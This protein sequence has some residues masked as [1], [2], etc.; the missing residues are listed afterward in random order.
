MQQ[1][2]QLFGHGTW[3]KREETAVPYVLGEPNTEAAFV[4]NYW[5]FD[6]TRNSQ[7]Y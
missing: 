4:V 3:S 7:G 5:G 2:Q 6:I 1:P